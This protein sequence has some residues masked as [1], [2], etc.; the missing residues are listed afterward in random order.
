MSRNQT[1]ET[2]EAPLSAPEELGPAAAPEERVGYGRPPLHS[3]FKPGHSGNP[4]GRPRG[5]R[6]TST[7]VSEVLDR[8]IIV[9]SAGRQE[10]MQV[11][12]AMI[13]RAVEAGLQGN[14]KA[15]EFVLKYD[16][17]TKPAN[18]V[19]ADTDGP[20]AALD[21]A[22]IIKAFSARCKPNPED[23]A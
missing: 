21:D 17:R 6:N 1:D 9:K 2:D 23:G 14:L 20:D 7:I 12:E 8:K 18:L 4:K 19:Q 10:K 11:R 13:T 3:R 5:A 15:M 22:A 16:E